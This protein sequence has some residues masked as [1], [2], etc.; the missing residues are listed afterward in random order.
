MT[1]NLNT[2]ALL[3][4][5]KGKSFVSVFDLTSEA[6]IFR[7]PQLEIAESINYSNDGK[8]SWLWHVRPKKLGMVSLFMMLHPARK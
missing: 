3:H 1:N 4:K 6:E 7:T 5:E 8:I 2:V